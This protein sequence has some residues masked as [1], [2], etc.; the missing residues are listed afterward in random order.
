MDA[1]IARL[2]DCTVFQSVPG[3]RVIVSS[4]ATYLTGSWHWSWFAVN[5]RRQGVSPFPKCTARR[6]GGA[7]K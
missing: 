7:W 2:R 6:T 5:L 1:L 3:A 4:D